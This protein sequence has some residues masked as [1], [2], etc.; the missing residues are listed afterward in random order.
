ML[1]VSES[2]SDYDL[3]R[4]EGISDQEKTPA[5]TPGLPAEDWS[6]LVDDFFEN[7]VDGLAYDR[8]LGAEHFS[9]GTVNTGLTAAQ[10]KSSNVRL[11]PPVSL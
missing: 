2:E 3:P 7:N 1:K 10:P 4:L 8:L 6:R 11:L 5:V 9:A